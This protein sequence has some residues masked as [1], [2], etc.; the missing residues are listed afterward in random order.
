M[1]ESLRIKSLKST[2]IRGIES[3]CLSLLRMTFV[4][5]LLLLNDRLGFT[6]LTSFRAFAA[7]ETFRAA[8]GIAVFRL[9]DE[10]ERIHA[11]TP[12]HAAMTR[13]LTSAYRH[14]CR[15]AEPVPTRRAYNISYV[16]SDSRLQP[17]P[18]LLLVAR[19]GT[20]IKNDS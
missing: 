18:F 5:L 10:G 6:R 7:R 1:T 8:R 2:L 16:I 3:Y 14:Y 19:I 17:H 15:S 13:C 9:T 20:F 11:E 12:V 4:L